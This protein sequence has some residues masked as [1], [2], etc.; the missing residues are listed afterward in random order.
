MY[1]LKDISQYFTKGKSKSKKHSVP[2]GETMPKIMAKLKSNANYNYYECTTTFNLKQLKFSRDCD[3]L[4]FH[5]YKYYQGKIKKYIKRISH[6]DDYYFFTIPEY[7]KN[8][9]L[10]FHTVMYFKYEH[11]DTSNRFIVY[12]NKNFGN[13][14]GKK[15]HNLDNWIKYISKDYKKTNKF[16]YIWLTHHRS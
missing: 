10:H 11:I 9:L 12:S 4:N 1:K 13:T 2:L 8:G 3:N 16:Q 14:R 6:N 15:I 5:L 7:Q